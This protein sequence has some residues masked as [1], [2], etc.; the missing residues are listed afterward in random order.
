[1]NHSP[2]SQFSS[3]GDTRPVPALD[4]LAKGTDVFILQNMGPI[5]DLDALS[6]ES[7]LLIKVCLYDSV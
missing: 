1:V 3:T 5:E 2:L 6:Y 4:E 7:K